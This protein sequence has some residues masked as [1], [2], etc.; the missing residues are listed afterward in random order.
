MRFLSVFVAAALCASSAIAHADYLYSDS[1]PDGGFSFRE[2]FLSS[3]PFTVTQ[4]QTTGLYSELGFTEFDVSPTDPNGFNCLTG[5]VPNQSCIQASG[6]GEQLYLY[7]LEPLVS[8]GQIP[9][10]DG[11]PLE[12]SYVPPDVAPTPE[13]SSFALLGLGLLGVVGLTRR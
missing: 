4:F 9:G 10:F 11:P 6:T 8:V 1:G 2:R 7:F 5:D 3:K 13:P 12:I